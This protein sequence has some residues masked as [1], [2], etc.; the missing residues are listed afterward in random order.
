MFLLKGIREF[1]RLRL[2]ESKLRQNFLEELDE[3]S[4]HPLG[5]EG[6]LATYDRAIKVLTRIDGTILEQAYLV[7]SSWIALSLLMTRAPQ[8]FESLGIINDLLKLRV[9]R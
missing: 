5:G 2:E 3:L 7:S 9:E 6:Y 1:Y 4:R 8:G